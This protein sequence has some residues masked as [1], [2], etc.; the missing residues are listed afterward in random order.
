MKVRGWKPVDEDNVEDTAS[1]ASLIAIPSLTI[2]SL[3]ITSPVFFVVEFRQTVK[4]VGQLVTRLAQGLDFSP[5]MVP[6]LHHFRTAG[7]ESIHWHA[8][9]RVSARSSVVSRF[10]AL[11]MSHKFDG[12]IWGCEND[13]VVV[14]FP[15]ASTHK[16][17][18]V[19]TMAYSAH[20]QCLQLTL[21]SVCET[22]SPQSLG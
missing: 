20:R 11:S 7:V 16:R 8:F 4:G 12:G 15:T 5:T 17:R 18:R 1:T 22:L 19:G 14:L 3:T 2:T 10:S 6:H 13:G 21:S 9:F